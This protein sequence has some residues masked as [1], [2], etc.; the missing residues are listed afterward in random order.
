MSFDQWMA[1]VD[2]LLET[3]FGLSSMDIVD[4]TWRAWF[5]DGLTPSQAAADII[6][7]PWSHI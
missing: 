5:D 7:D 1:K 4:Q 6:N 3:E 2:L